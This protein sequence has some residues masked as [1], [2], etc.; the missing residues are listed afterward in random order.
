LDSIY[1]RLEGLSTEVVNIKDEM[2]VRHDELYNRMKTMQE[3][4]V[5]TADLI[6]AFAE[7]QKIMDQTLLSLVQ[8]V[9]V[10]GQEEEIDTLISSSAASRQKESNFGVRPSSVSGSDAPSSKS[11]S[12][13]QGLST[14]E[15]EDVLKI[16]QPSYVVD[17]KST[18]DN[19]RVREPEG[20]SSVDDFVQ[21]MGELGVKVKPEDYRNY[22]LDILNKFYNQRRR[23]VLGPK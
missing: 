18:P 9:T 3:N 6:R 15:R 21:K 23:A 1:D 8:Y 16:G 19:N 4:L 20:V 17:K 7:K 11:S 22:T 2:I 10:Q 14:T 5:E 13:R 12:Y